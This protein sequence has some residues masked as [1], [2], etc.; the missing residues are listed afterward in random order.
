MSDKKRFRIPRFYK[1]LLALTVVVGPITWLMLTDDGRRRADLMVLA[2]TDD[3]MVEMRLAPLT[4]AFTEA[5]V[6]EFMP[7]EVKWQCSNSRSGFG[8]RSCVTPIAS[9]NDTPAHY[10]VMYFQEDA[11]QAMKMVYRDDYHGYLTELLTQML[12]EPRSDDGVLRWKTDHGLVLLPKTLADDREEPSMLW[13]SASRV[14]QF[15]GQE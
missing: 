6:R 2:F 10:L 7:D 1:T 13:L 5:Q 4:S 3:P 14:K 9:F 12:D 11:L 8:E 15:T